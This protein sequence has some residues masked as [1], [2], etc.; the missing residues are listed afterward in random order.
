MKKSALALDKG[1]GSSVILY[2]YL[3]GIKVRKFNTRATT[4]YCAIYMT[5]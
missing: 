2:F 1:K 3:I 4:P 5:F